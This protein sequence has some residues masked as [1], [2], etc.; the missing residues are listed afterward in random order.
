LSAESLVVATVVAALVG[1][2]G[3]KTVVFAIQETAEVETLWERH[4]GGIL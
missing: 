4:L 1:H 3:K 2:H